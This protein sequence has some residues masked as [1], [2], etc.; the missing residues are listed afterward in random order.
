MLAAMRR[1][2]GSLVPLELWVLSAIARLAKVGAG[3]SHGYEIAKH[4]AEAS[5][6]RLLTAYGTL[7][8]ALN[9]LEK[10]GLLES[11]WED[12]HIAAQ[13]A[14]P[15]RRLYRLTPAGRAAAVAE[16][17]DS[18]RLPARSRKPVRA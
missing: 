6:R 18:A 9:R 17:R 4:V 16:S 3:E 10:M 14:R 7:Y 5:E 15:G 12:P 2:S 1:K 13:E 11:R 8:R